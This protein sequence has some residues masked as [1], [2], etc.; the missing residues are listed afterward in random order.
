[1]AAIVSE[2]DAGYDSS[3]LPSEPNPHFQ[4]LQIVPVDFLD[5]IDERAKKDGQSPEAVVHDVLA[6]YLQIA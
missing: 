3:D 4:R 2:A 6:T 1:M 5:A